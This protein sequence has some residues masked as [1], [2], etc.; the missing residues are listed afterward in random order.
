MG[1]KASLAEARHSLFYGTVEKTIA[2]MVSLYVG[3]SSYF[4]K[5]GGGE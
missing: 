4:V 1:V 3:D 5:G 2:L